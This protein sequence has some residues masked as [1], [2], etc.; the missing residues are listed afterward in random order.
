MKDSI[1]GAITLEGS[2]AGVDRG[3]VYYNGQP[4]CAEGSDGSTTWD[5]NASNVVC[6]MLG[7]S[8]ASTFTGD[9]CTYGGCSEGVPFAL[10]GFNCT[11]SETHIADCAHNQTIPSNCGTD[12]AT[13]SNQ[14]DIV[15]VQCTGAHL[16]HI[17]CFCAIM[18]REKIFT[19][20]PEADNLNQGFANFHLNNVRE[21]WWWGI[22]LNKKCFCFN[23]V[24]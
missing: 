18:K 7:F 6:K 8:S 15:G 14:N 13:N 24:K 3:H 19:Q 16:R 2:N 5:I 9:G 17:F 11:G 23:F 22:K 1:A 12:G 20:V 21:Q 10:S 4:I